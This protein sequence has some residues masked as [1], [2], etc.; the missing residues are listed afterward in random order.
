MV[1]LPYGYRETLRE[2]RITCQVFFEMRCLTV[3][4]GFLAGR[5]G[6][7]RVPACVRRDGNCG[8]YADKS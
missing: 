8:I 1:T 2:C 6:R 7:P 5:E 4:N 3:R